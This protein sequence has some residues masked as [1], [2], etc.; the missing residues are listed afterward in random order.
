MDSKGEGEVKS[1]GKSKKS[2][3][4]R[5]KLKGEMVKRFLTPKEAADYLHLPESEF[6][7]IVKKRNIPTY[8]IGGL[9]TR[10]KVDDLDYHSRKIRK[11]A[12]YKKDSNT[13]SDKIK[14]FFYFNDFYIFSSIAII[15]ILYFIFK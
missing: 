3:G 15:V 14:D 12:R 13:F 10:F 6:Q 7:E 2:K 5:Q 8:K 11:K 1:K 9:Y 4:K